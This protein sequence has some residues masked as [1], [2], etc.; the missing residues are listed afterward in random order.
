MLFL[1]KMEKNVMDGKKDT[2]KKK[3]LFIKK[4]LKDFKKNKEKDKTKYLS[5][6]IITLEK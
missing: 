1:Y 5:S 4:P 3:I 2:K 6:S